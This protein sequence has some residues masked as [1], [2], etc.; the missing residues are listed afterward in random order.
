LPVTS[1]VVPITVL[2]FILQILATILVVRVLGSMSG[3]LGRG[4]RGDT[5]EDGREKEP[6]YR[7]LTPYE[8]EE[9]EFEEIPGGKKK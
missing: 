1:A 6:D 7:D 3:L 5:P 9:A 2:R 4:K 8:I